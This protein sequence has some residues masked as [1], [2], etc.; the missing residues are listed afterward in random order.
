MSTPQSDN[1]QLQWGLTL[2][3][4]ETGTG[5]R[6]G[7]RAR[8]FNG[9]SLFRARKL[10]FANNY[11]LDLMALQ[12]GLTLSSEETWYYLRDLHLR[13][14][15]SMGPHSFERGNGGCLFLKARCGVASMGPHSFERGN[16]ECGRNLR[17][18]M[19]RFNGASLFRA[20]KPG[21]KATRGNPATLQWGLTLSSEETRG[22]CQALGDKLRASMGPH[23][24]E[25]GNLACSECAEQQPPSFNGASLFRARKP[26]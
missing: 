13:R 4:E 21:T 7:R 24:F 2:S 22:K 10:V 9:A 5:W 26:R 11:L 1:T 19:S 25:R 16:V 8:C 12:W 17:R 6:R 18:Y 20:R 15:A 23:S 14:Y 3:S